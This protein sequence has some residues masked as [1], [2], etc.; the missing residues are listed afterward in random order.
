MACGLFH[1]STG[2]R[3][4]TD[5]KTLRERMV[6]QQIEVRGIRDP[7]VLEAMRTVPRE[8]FVPENV[9]A[10]AYDDSPLPIEDGQTISQPYIV[11]LMTE[12][13]EV[14]PGNRVLEIG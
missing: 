3:Q 2:R 9:R 11:A 14:G 10:H 7:R 5:W 12:L 13:L 1:R 6:Q 8:E 4:T